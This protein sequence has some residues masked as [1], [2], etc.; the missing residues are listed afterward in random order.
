[1]VS[2]PVGKQKSIHGPAV[3]V[4]SKLDTLCNELPRLPSQ[5]EL[6]PLKLKLKLSY[7]GH[8]LYD[9]VTPERLL[10]ALRYLKANNHYYKDISINENWITHAL[11]DDEDLMSSLMENP[12][13]TN[14]IDMINNPSSSIE[15]SFSLEENQHFTCIT[16]QFPSFPSLPPVNTDPPPFHEEEDHHFNSS[17]EPYSSPP[18]PPV[19]IKHLNIY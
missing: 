17:L 18:P 14:N 9:Y 2:L 3:N 10:N 1:M 8:Y 13:I 5:S 7:K 6:I 16:N 12:H 19:V 4:P 15:A 11:E